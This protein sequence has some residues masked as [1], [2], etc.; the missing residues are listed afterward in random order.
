MCVIAY[1]VFLYIDSHA[2][3]TSK[4]GQLHIFLIFICVYEAC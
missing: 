2:H 1:V 4:G 3:L